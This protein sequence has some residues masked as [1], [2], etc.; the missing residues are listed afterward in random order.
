[1]IANFGKGRAL[2]LALGATVAVA[3][4][5]AAKPAEARWYGGVT[6]GVGF[7]PFYYPGYVYAP[8]VY[9]APPPVYYGYPGYYSSYGY[10][11]HRTVHH[12]VSHAAAPSCTC[13]TPQSNT[14]AGA[15][16]N[17]GANTS[18]QSAPTDSNREA[19]NTAPGSQDSVY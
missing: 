18:A 15:S 19:N 5:V 9:Y 16:P 4:M 13:P 10:T 7:A 17:T 12:H 8:P 6:V 2:G 3:G 14:S 11:T 1:M